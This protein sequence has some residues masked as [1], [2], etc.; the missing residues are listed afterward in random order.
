LKKELPGLMFER[1]SYCAGILY[2]GH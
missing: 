2:L 1:T